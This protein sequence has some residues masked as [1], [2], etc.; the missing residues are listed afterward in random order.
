MEFPVESYPEVIS[1]SFTHLLPLSSPKRKLMYKMA[2][3]KHRVSQ[4]V[5]PALSY[6]QL[7]LRHP[8]LVA[9]QQAMR[10]KGGLAG[11]FQWFRLWELQK[12]CERFKPESVCELGCGSSSYVF[13][14][15]IGDPKRGG[16]RSDFTAVDES[17]LWLDRM[18]SYAG[19]LKERVRPLR[20]DRKVMEKDGESVVFYDI[21]HDRHFDLI[22]VDGPTSQP[23]PEDGAVIVKDPLGQM[24]NVDVELFWESGIFPRV[25]VIDGRRP[26]VRRLLQKMP[27][28]YRAYLKADFLHRTR[29]VDFSRDRY[30]TL[31]VRDV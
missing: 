4:K 2:Y 11:D 21:P 6:L 17:S 1:S 27:P 7:R 29:I 25:I 23:K 18:M 13:A 12:L 14:S 15:F 19:P 5:L 9:R 16:D 8:D 10:E 28:G 24:P 31:L 20:G 30:H 22:Y 3:R 26:T